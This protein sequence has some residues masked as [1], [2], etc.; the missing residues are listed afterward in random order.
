VLG[1]LLCSLRFSCV[2]GSKRQKSTIWYMYIIWCVH[3]SRIIT[4]DE[5]NEREVK[6]NNYT[7]IFTDGSVDYSSKGVAEQR[8]GAF[9]NQLMG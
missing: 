5:T 1:S 9:Q 6:S 7:M 2:E 4:K 8:V 3:N